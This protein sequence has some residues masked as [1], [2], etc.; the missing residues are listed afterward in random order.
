MPPPPED[1]RV[2]FRSFVAA[3]ERE[4]PDPSW[5]TKTKKGLT[6][7]LQGLEK[8]AHFSRFQLECRSKTCKGEI[9]WP[10]FEQAN[11]NIPAIL[12]N[13]YSINSGVRFLLPDR[14]TAG[15]P[16]TVSVLFEPQPNN[17]VPVTYE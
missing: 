8:I 10:S 13:Q 5:A 9:E 16:C 11:A 2:L 12:H 14:P 17:T 3:Y 1:G 6:H 4:A 15:A 7:D